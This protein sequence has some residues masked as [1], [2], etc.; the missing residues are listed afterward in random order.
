M[1][2]VKKIFTG[3]VCCA[4]MICVTGCVSYKQRA[5][6][7]SGQ[8]QHI[9]V[10]M[11]QPQAQELAGK[12]NKVDTVPTEEYNRDAFR[13]ERLHT[14]FYPGVLPETIPYFST[15]WQYTYPVGF[16]N[17]KSCKY[18]LY[19]DPDGELFGWSCDNEVVPPD[20]MDIVRRQDELIKPPLPTPPDP[21]RRINKRY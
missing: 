13:L 8:L 7:I 6:H 2:F 19:F 20:W 5:M 14:T 11:T 15:R 4:V 16:L 1:H 10:G 21:N 12:P 18:A 17:L 3:F 9:R